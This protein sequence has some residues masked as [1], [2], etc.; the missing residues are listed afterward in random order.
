MSYDLIFLDKAAGQ[1]WDEALE[2][3]EEDDDDSGGMPDG[4]QWAAVVAGAR[5]IL[6]EVTE[7]RG[8]GYYELDHEPTG[9]QLSLYVGSAGVAVPYWY[10]GEDAKRIV[11]AI[12]GLG[13][14]VER[15]TGLEGY[16]RQIELPIAEAEARPDLAAAVFDQITVGRPR[17]LDP[18]A[19]R[20]P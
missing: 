17:T 9:I 3:I 16:D 8:D 10:R 15:S 13:R 18:G 12:Y 20:L 19:L 6:G 2:A 7:F 14:V 4:G 1:S 11:D 5:E